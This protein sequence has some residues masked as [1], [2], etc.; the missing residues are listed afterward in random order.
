ML[1]PA[2]LSNLRTW[3]Y[4]RD[5][6]EVLQ[7]MELLSAVLAGH[8]PRAEFYAVKSA[9]ALVEALDQAMRARLASKRDGGN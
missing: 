9:L 2:D 7:V 5:G 1:T 6:S 3:L 8:A 4:R